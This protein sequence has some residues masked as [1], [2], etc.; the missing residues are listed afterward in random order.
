MIRRVSEPQITVAFISSYPPRECGIATFTSDLINNAKSAGGDRFEPVV[1]A[2]ESGDEHQY[3]DNVKFRIRKD[4]LVDYVA[5][6]N[7]INFSD[8][9]VVSVQHEFGL[10]GGLAGAYL[11]LL[12]DLIDKPV[13]TTLHTVLKNPSPEYFNSTLEVCRL[14]DELIVMNKR[15]IS[16]LEQIYGVRRAKI[17][18]VPHGIPDLPFTNGSECRQKLGLAGRRLILTFGL[19]SKNKGI[20][21]MLE[22]LP[23]IVKADPSVLYLVL[24]P[25]HPEVLRHE[26]RSYIYKLER[27]VRDLGM[28]EHVVFHN[29]FVTNE[30]LSE[31]LEAADIYVTPYLNKAQLTSGTLAFAVGA[32]K[33][34]VSTPYWAAEELLADGRGRLVEFADSA[35][36]ARS[37]VAI[38]KDEELFLRMKTRAYEYGRSR[39]WPKIGEAYWD[40][41]ETYSQIPMPERSQV[42]LKSPT[43]PMHDRNAFAPEKLG[44][45]AERTE[46]LSGH[47]RMI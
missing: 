40:L 15:G 27:M 13:V 21:Y 32:G 42:P 30:H 41:F 19:L 6:A 43:T 7:F 24:G 45:S 36:I 26:G 3:D 1:I 5:A 38:L 44:N 22:A 4:V 11:G 28:E 31:L 47:K 12:L 35:G 33:A 37:V 20:E 29:R 2:V 17:R 39:T 46:I 16:M 9:D 10:F 8:V 14:S 25:T 23:A 34:V 18:L